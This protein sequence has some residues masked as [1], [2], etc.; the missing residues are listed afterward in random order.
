MNRRRPA[1]L[2][3]VFLLASAAPSRAQRVEVAPVGGYRFG[4]DLFESAVGAPVDADG[5][6]ALGFAIDVPMSSGL[7]FEGLFSHQRG[8][9]DVFTDPFGRPARVDVSVDHFQVGGLQEYRR[10]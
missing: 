5:A 6:P 7:Q 9:V 10:P 2:V 8:T 4:N 1:W 3:A